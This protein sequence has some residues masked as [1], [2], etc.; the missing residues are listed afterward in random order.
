MSLQV[1]IT[2]WK[3]LNCY[4]VQIKF[5]YLLFVWP[6]RENGG[7]SV[8]GMHAMTT[9]LNFSRL[10]P[11]LQL[12]RKQ[13]LSF[14]PATECWLEVAA[15]GVWLTQGPNDIV[16]HAPHRQL[17]AAGRRVVVEAVT[18][19][20]ALSLSLDRSDA[21]RPAAAR[22]LPSLKGAVACA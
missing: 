7:M 1:T 5:L 4:C 16:L 11:L 9:C 13:L 20:A 6:G 18:V 14:V 21:H 3:I 22:E 2:D 15:G 10:D 19:T 17:L 8:S 12:E